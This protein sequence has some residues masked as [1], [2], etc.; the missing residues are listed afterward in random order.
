MRIS[1]VVV[2]TAAAFLLSSVSRA[3]EP[4]VSVGKPRLRDI[5]YTPD[6][7]SLATLTSEYI[8]FLD[9]DTHA[10]TRRLA[11]RHAHG[12]LFSPDG[13][14][15]AVLGGGKPVDV[16]DADTLESVA[17][18]PETAG[19][20]RVAFSPDGRLLALAARDTVV[21]R[22]TATWQAVSALTGDDGALLRWEMSRDG[23]AVDRHRAQHVTSLAFHPEGNTLA[24]GSVRTT[25]ALWSVETASIVARLN[26]SRS[27]FATDLHYSGDGRFLLGATSGA[28]IALW[29]DVSPDARFVKRPGTDWPE[30]V[31][32]AF[33]RD[34][35]RALVGDGQARLRI[36]DTATLDERI[37]L[38]PDFGPDPPRIQS[39]LNRL[40]T[41]AW[42]PDGDRLAGAIP[43]SSIVVWN[44]PDY[45]VRTRVYGYR[46]DLPNALYLPELD[47]VV[48]GFDSTAICSWD[49][50]TGELVGAL[51][52]G[53]AIDDLAAH[54]DG[55]RI[56]VDAHAYTYMVDV[57]SMEAIHRWEVGGYSTQ[58]AF[59]PSGAHLLRHGWFGTHVW[60]VS[61]GERL[62][63]VG[64]HSEG[65]P[66]LFTTDERDI[67]APTPEEEPM[68]AHWDIA[69]GESRRAMRDAG[70]V[71]HVRGIT[72]MARR[73]GDRIA[74]VQMPF[75]QEVWSLPSPPIFDTDDP[76]HRWLRFS[77]TGALVAINHGGGGGPAPVR[78]TFYL[79][80][81]GQAVGSIDGHEDFRLVDDD[82]HIF[83]RNDDGSVGLFRTGDILRPL[84]VD[85]V[86]LALTKW[87]SVKRTRLLPNYPNPFN[88]ETWI[89]FELAERGTVRVRVYDTSGAV[90]RD[91]PLGAL[92]AGEYISRER[93]AR[94][95]GRNASGET[96][97]SGS[98]VIEMQAGDHIE[99]RRVFLAK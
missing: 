91:L 79:A 89:P 42:H 72:L 65:P 40:D 3:A 34:S 55:S 64:T 18:L 38:A 33:S 44:A 96:V 67:I 99:R 95:D 73:T 86:R 46:Q 81:R 75:G 61:T 84:G 82:R 30:A 12:L 87:G 35:Q 2:A 74:F 57:V 29:S 43:R 49:A 68:M 14:F 60:D 28:G 41:L 62:S 71:A 59:S 47:R 98:Y 48:T 78:F 19:K 20:G 39:G 90:V 4:I 22:E 52:F 50:R 21:L 69:T 80:H 76:M 24:V 5:V 10:A 37:L 97:A 93:A 45:S 17:T 92:P 70:P 66:A 26:I 27:A 11:R 8:E 25:V 58:L 63:L 23:R 36:I 54:P 56:A 9:A 85:G 88:P 77:D 13:R 53:S 51:Q 31:S 94:W 16:L 1:R 83:L 7:T 6:G 32:L 15:L